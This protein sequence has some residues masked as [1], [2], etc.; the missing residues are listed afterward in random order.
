MFHNE[1]FL[2]L[3]LFFFNVRHFQISLVL[4]WSNWGFAALFLDADPLRG[5]TPSEN[6]G[7]LM[8]FLKKKVY[9]DS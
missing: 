5:A 6:Q 8:K 2:S 7:I 9:D 4:D 1:E 3:F